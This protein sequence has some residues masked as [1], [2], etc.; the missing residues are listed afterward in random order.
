MYFSHII[1]VLFALA[2]FVVASPEAVAK[3][4]PSAQPDSNL[5]MRGIS[6]G[7]YYCTGANWSSKCWHRTGLKA[8]AIYYVGPSYNL[9]V[10]SF[11]PDKGTRCTLCVHQ[12]CSLANGGAFSDLIHYPGTG[13][14]ASK[15]LK[16]WDY[17]DRYGGRS[18]GDGWWNDK[19]SAFL[20]YPE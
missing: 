16:V 13:N 18:A 19:V 7:V 11:G 20:C 15:A 10:H 3:P 6:L 17:A 4:E 9:Q 8:G 12:D 14:L 5:E 1:S 2:T